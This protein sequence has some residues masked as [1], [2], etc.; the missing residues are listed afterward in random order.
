MSESTDTTTHGVSLTDGAAEKFRLLLE[1][2]NQPG[3]RLRV[4]VRPGGCGVSYQMVFD[5][6]VLDGDQLRDFNGVG[7]VVDRFSA[8]FLDGAT[9]GFVDTPGQQ[10]FT[11]DNPNMGGGGCCG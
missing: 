8:P 10:G 7:V 4:A 9:I 1:Q 11:I 5:N 3:L 2:E 6:Q